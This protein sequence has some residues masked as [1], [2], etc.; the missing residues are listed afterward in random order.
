MD[1]GRASDGR[2]ALLVPGRSRG[3]SQNRG[4]EGQA[5]EQTLGWCSSYSPTCSD[6]GVGDTC[7]TPGRRLFPSLLGRGKG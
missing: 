6:A 1:L 5:K 2:G 4:V 7:G 3:K